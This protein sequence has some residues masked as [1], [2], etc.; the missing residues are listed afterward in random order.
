MM[1]P[2]LD[3]DFWKEHG[4]NAEW[5]N[6]AGF[7]RKFP[8]G[9]RLG[10]AMSAYMMMTLELIRIGVGYTIKYIT[11]RRM[12]PTDWYGPWVMVWI[13]M[14][15]AYPLQMGSRAP[16]KV[17]KRMRE[18]DR[19][20]HYGALLLQA[21]SLFTIVFAVANWEAYFQG[22]NRYAP[23][24]INKNGVTG[25]GGPDI[26]DEPFRRLMSS[27]G[28]SINGE[29]GLLLITSAVAL[30]FLS[31]MMSNK[32]AVARIRTR[33]K[34]MIRVGKS[35][36]KRTSAL[37]TTI[38]G[39]GPSVAGTGSGS[40]ATYEEVEEREMGPEEVFNSLSESEPLTL[41]WRVQGGDDNMLDR[42]Y[43]NAPELDSMRVLRMSDSELADLVSRAEVQIASLDDKIEVL[44]SDGW[45]WA[46]S[47]I[48]KTTSTEINEVKE[49]ICRLMFK[50]HVLP[51]AYNTKTQE[52]MWTSRMVID[53]RPWDE[54]DRRLMIML[55]S[56]V[57]QVPEDA[58]GA[59]PSD[60]FG[61]NV[62]TGEFISREA[63]PVVLVAEEAER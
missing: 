16:H 31:D 6:P 35:I 19:T 28:S 26:N 17:F 24:A 23:M 60:R 3:N 9:P 58:R 38:T 4:P 27:H 62:V 42:L 44:L 14:N 21:S 59:A 51:K 56:M 18:K 52:P 61:V 32:K 48:A 10:Q 30:S 43:Q 34:G 36:R 15:V 46:A 20:M 55:R 22:K 37:K 54:S 13:Y 29:I 57:F 12:W 63:E 47:G 2:Y 7:D 41:S 40:V 11:L 5:M 25:N 1:I 39:G 53:G 45:I 8:L 33:S 49:A 50:G